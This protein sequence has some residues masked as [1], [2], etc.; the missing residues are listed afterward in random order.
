MYIRSNASLATSIDPT[1]LTQDEL[2][3]A[4]AKTTT[5]L[6]ALSKEIV[7]LKACIS[8]ARNDMQR[9]AALDKS[10]VDGGLKETRNDLQCLRQNIGQVD[11]FL[12]A[13]FSTSK[14]TSVLA[15]S[16]DPNHQV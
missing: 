12:R 9:S 10:P 14:S 3:R 7:D 11:D 1:R 16:S 8:N 13:R 2:Q 5:A 15:S 6:K 4:G